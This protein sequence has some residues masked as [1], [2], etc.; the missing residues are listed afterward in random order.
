[1][2]P[3]HVLEIE[4]ALVE[5]KRYWSLPAQAGGPVVT[6]EFL[7]RLRDCVWE[8]VRTGH[9]TAVMLSG[10]VD[11]ASILALAAETGE[12]LKAY[13]VDFPEA[14]GTTYSEAELAREQAAYSQ[15]KHCVIPITRQDIL[16][17]LSRAVQESQGLCV[18]GH[19]RDQR[20][21]C[22]CL[23]NCHLIISVR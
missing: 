4:G 23:D 11:S 3:G 5:L 13:T 8:R 6:E 19:H 20:L 1:M 16:K 18:N 7:E 12:R 2:P 10:G 21:Q 22:T 14:L 15:V 9:L 17:G